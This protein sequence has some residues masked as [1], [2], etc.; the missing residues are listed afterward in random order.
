[1]NMQI[2][3]LRIEFAIHYIDLIAF[4]QQ[5]KCFT[6]T[7]NKSITNLFIVKSIEVGS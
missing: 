2:V 7:D 4:D 3:M 6:D 1:M 5:R